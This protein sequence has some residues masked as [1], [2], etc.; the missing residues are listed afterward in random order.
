MKTAITASAT[1]SDSETIRHATPEQ[2]AFYRE[3]GYL[4]FGRIFTVAEMDALDDHVGE[5]IATLPAGKRPEQMDVPHFEDPWLFRY[6]AAPRVLDIIED[7]IGPDIILWSSHFIAKPGGDGRA[8]PW[9]TD[10]AYWQGL[11]HPMEVITLWLAVDPSSVAN[12]CM[13][14][15]PGSHRAIRTAVESYKP[16]DRETNLFPIELPAEQMDESQAVDLELARGE[17]HFHDAWTIHGSSPNHSALRRCGYTMRYMPAHVVLTRADWN[18]D[19]RIYLL[20]GQD[21]TGGKNDYTPI[22]TF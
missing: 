7:F 13:R 9:H 16:V 18:R 12:G 2:V 1:W 22:P 8:V 21:R 20:R 10:G 5:M 17:C 11:L 15:L 3:Q 6:L 19:H 14:V 4:R